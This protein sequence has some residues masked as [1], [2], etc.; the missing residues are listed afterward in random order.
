[1]SKLSNMKRRLSTVLLAAFAAVLMAVPAFATPASTIEDV[2]DT[3][4][5]DVTTLITGTLA[6]AFFA[7]TL[8]VLAVVVGWKWLRRGAKQG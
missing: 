6:T 8:V 2:I 5:G 7:I 1:M 3:S 4:F